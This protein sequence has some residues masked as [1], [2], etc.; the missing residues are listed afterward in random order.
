MVKFLLVLNFPAFC[1]LVCELDVLKRS[2]CAQAEYKVHPGSGI[3]LLPQKTIP[4]IAQRGVKI[5]GTQ[6]LCTQ[7]SLECSAFISTQEIP[8]VFST[9]SIV[10]TYFQIPEKRNVKF[11]GGTVYASKLRPWYNLCVPARKHYNVDHLGSMTCA[12]M[13]THGRFRLP[14]LHKKVLPHPGLKPGSQAQQRYS[15]APVSP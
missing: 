5:P 12:K 11:G 6:Y 3:I 13:S 8:N 15:L 9:A 10:N 1:S 14:R 2:H 7:L 4:N